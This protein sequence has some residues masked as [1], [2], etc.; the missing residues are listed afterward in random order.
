MRV[1][2]VG[3]G[4]KGPMEDVVG[5]R[6][7]DVV[8]KI[9]G[10]KGTKVRLDLVPP[11]VPIES[12]PNRVL[13]TRDIV[14]LT[15]DAAKS[16]IIEVPAQNGQP[17]KRIG[18]IKLPSFYE[19]FEGRR[20]GGEF[21]SS[22][23]DV[24]RLLQGFQG[25]N[26]DG[27][28]LDFRNN[29]GGSLG[30]AVRITG[31]FIDQG[32]VVQV[33]E[34]GGRVTVN[35][36]RTPGVMWR[37]PLAIVINRATASASEIVA[38]AIKDYGRGIIIGET[39]YGKGTVQNLMDLDRWPGRGAT[40]YGQLKLTIA[41]FFLPGGSSTQ[42]KGVTPD[43]HYPV[44]VD[45]A[46]FGESTND[47]A[48]PWSKIDS[49][50]FERVGDLTALNATLE[51][52]HKARV[53]TDPEFKWLLE[54]LAEYKERKDRKYIS[55]NEAE[56]KAERDAAEAK[57]KSRQEARKRLGLALDPLADDPAD[58]GL[59]LN[60]RDVAKQVEREKQADKRP[61]PLLRESA[62]ILVDAINDLGRDPA[63]LK[64]SLPQAE[65]PVLWVR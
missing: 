11:G 55:L 1:I 59:S 37:G 30:E 31:L 33:R 16:E 50:D 38:G 45:A 36:D 56:R 44:T 54:D 39:T 4:E 29:G 28:V 32:P 17:A 7:D 14:K 57:V 48:L 24:A 12:K 21:A 60:E 9:K 19:D 35:Q 52:Q 43:V 18:V 40:N 22:S 20:R 49:S 8:E 2:A 58:D 51:G 25:Q 23:R 62:N 47:N 41:Q 46:D 13:L 42:N 61:D 65:S 26:I 53:Q 27:V 15:E 34:S 10:D 3:Q 5:W 64:R 6:I 63:L